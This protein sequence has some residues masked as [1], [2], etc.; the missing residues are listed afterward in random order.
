M[1]CRGNAGA[2]VA[3]GAGRI[4]EATPGRHGYLPK[5]YLFGTGILRHLREAAVPSIRLLSTIAPVARQP[6]GGVIENQTAIDLA[7]R[8]SALC[9]WK[10]TPSGGEIDFI[11]KSDTGTC[12]VE[13]KASLTFD[14]KNIRGICDYL[15]LYGQRVGVVVSLAPYS[16]LALPDGREVIDL[17]AYLL[18]RL[19]H[20]AIGR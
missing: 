17:P 10:K 15:T 5:R 3:A 18:E 12:P 1:T 7:R 9:G 6:L 4:G 19:P 11:A 13:C 20:F 14:R 8:G 16:A 2:M